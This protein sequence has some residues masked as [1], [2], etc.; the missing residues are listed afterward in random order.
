MLH[1][2]STN[3]NAVAPKTAVL[4]T[5]ITEKPLTTSALPKSQTITGKLS[6]SSSKKS[7]KVT[8]RYTIDDNG[9]SYEGL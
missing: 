4:S 1:Y 6:F 3:Q 2:S 5:V 9:G 7:Y 8:R